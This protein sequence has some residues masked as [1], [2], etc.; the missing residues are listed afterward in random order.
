MA[1]KPM[2]DNRVKRRG[3]ALITPKQL[4]ERYLHGVDLLDKEGNALPERAIQAFIDSAVSM[5]ETDL[6]IYIVPTK[7]DPEEKDYQ[8][9][10][11]WGWGYFQ[12]NNIPVISIESLT[13]VYPGATPSNPNS[14]IL[15][16]PPEWMKL[17]KHDG[18]LRLIPIANV[19][20]GMQFDAA[21]GFFP[22][23][24]SR[25][26]MV[27]LLW[28][29]T[30]TSG[31]EDGCIPMNINAAI[32]MIAA[33]FCLN[34][35]GADIL[36]PGVTSSTLYIDGL[37]QSLNTA[38]SSTSHAYS[39]PIAEYRRLLFGEPATGDRGIIAALRDYWKGINLAVF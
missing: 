7:H 9:N 3:E 15:T 27:P 28:Q 26:S 24:F 19:P 36:A 14:N 29:V 35:L 25:H 5:L 30:Y 13:A 23:M 22:E 34:A 21:G 4:K 31:F 16:I 32:G 39:G 6:D 33:I 2:R 20:A 12:L 11:Y 38:L 37:S 17:Q 1:E 18:L 8:F 10:D